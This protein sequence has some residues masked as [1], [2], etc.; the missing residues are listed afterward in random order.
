MLIPRRHAS[1][2]LVAVAA[3]LVTGSCAV[4]QERGELSGESADGRVR[5]SLSEQTARSAFDSYCAARPPN[6]CD[7]FD[8]YN[9]EVIFDE[10][11][12]GMWFFHENPREAPSP[13]GVSIGCAWAL[14]GH[15]ECHSGRVPH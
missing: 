6:T 12:F 13:D 2:A 1:S 8:R 15:R 11:V 4:G 7:S 9:M 5:F 14:R 10:D 3:L